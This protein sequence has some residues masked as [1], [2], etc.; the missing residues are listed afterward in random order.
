MSETIN[1]SGGHVEHAYL[2]YIQLGD[3]ASPDKLIVEYGEDIDKS[4]ERYWNYFQKLT[5]EAQITIL[6]AHLE[7]MAQSYRKQGIVPTF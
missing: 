5:K 4:A 7:F 6:K 3:P 2:L 1:V